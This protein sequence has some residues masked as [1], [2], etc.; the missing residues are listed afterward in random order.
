MEPLRVFDAAVLA[1]S[2]CFDLAAVGLRF[3]AQAQQVE[4]LFCLHDEFS[5]IAD[6]A[7]RS[8]RRVRSMR[9][10]ES[11]RM[12]AVSSCVDEI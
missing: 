1:E 6:P 8:G 7:G 10:E 5:P 9:S 3:W 4:K 11:T 12:A 2:E